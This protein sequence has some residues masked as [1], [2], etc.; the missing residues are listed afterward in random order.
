VSKTSAASTYFTTQ[1]QSSCEASAFSWVRTLKGAS[2]AL[3]Y[4]VE[5]ESFAETALP[6]AAVGVNALGHDTSSDVS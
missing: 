1:I 6:G 4:F 2:R 3:A 5:A